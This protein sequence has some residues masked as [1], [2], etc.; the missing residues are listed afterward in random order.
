[1]S[2][3]YVPIALQ[4]E[5]T[6]RARRYCEYCRCSSLFHSDPFSIEHIIPE[7]LGGD[8]ITANLAFACLGCNK[9]KSIFTVAIDP[10]AEQEVPLFHPRTQIWEEHFAWN[11]DFTLVIGLTSSGRATVERLRLNRLGLVNLR[12]ALHH[13]GVHPPT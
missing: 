7:V 10:V 12:R 5:V 3:T 13:F 11:D 9:Y 4:R 8:T 6:E 2:K 1:M